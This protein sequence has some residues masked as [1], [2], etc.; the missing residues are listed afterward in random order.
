[1][2]KRR[3]F[4]GESMTALCGG[5]LALNLLLILA[6]LGLIARNGLATFW[7]RDLERFAMRDGRVL[8]GEVTAEA[9]APARSGATGHRL[10]VRIGNRD[11]GAA[12]FVWIDETAI[13]ERSRR[14][15]LVTRRHGRR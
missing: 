1:M 11:L 10:Q 13:A 15:P 3:E 12:D 2:S 5:A 7:P 9:E 4:F 14:H 8:L 6:L